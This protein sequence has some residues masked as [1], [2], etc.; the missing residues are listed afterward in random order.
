MSFDFFSDMEKEVMT[1]RKK[2]GNGNG[3]G[4]PKRG[5]LDG[6][7]INMMTEMQNDMDADMG[8]KKRVVREPFREEGFLEGFDTGELGGAFN[9]RFK[10]IGGGFIESVNA[11][12]SSIDFDKG[13]GQGDSIS[14]VFQTGR[15]FASRGK[16]ESIADREAR[17]IRKQRKKVGRPRK[18]GRPKG[19]TT[20]SNGNGAEKGERVVDVI[21]RKIKERKEKSQESSGFQ[22]T[23]VGLGRGTTLRT[24]GDLT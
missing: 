4:K 23:Q 1:P 9:G 3:N 2:N 22:S 19:S 11:G 5:F 24:E 8:I 18:V 13:A 20:V 21:R 12:R 14:P 17:S 6:F 7:D 16:L 10:N 15:R